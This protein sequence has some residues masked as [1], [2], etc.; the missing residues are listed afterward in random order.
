MK[1]RS[2]FSSLL[3]LTCVFFVLVSC[4]S[5]NAENDLATF[6]QTSV[7]KIPVKSILVF[8]VKSA[9]EKNELDYSKTR[10]IEAGIDILTSVLEDELSLQE[11]VTFVAEDQKESLMGDF[12][13]NEIDLIQHVAT[14]LGGDAVLITTLN[15]FIEREGRS[16]SVNQPASVAFTYR[17]IHAETGKTLCMGVFDETQQTLFSNIFSFSKAKKRGFKWISAEELTR[18]GVNEK[19]AECSYLSE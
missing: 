9:K 11:H 8:P 18:E 2:L 15:R 10:Q 17:L 5:K 13:G 1:P 12:R 3:I 4:S 7:Q 6:P 16:R 14:Q 19:F